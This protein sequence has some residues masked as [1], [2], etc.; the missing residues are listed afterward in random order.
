MAN[1]RADQQRIEQLR[2]RLRYAGLPGRQQYVRLYRMTENKPAIAWEASDVWC[3]GE[4]SIPIRDLQDGDIWQ[5]ILWLTRNVELLYQT[6]VGTPPEG[7]P[8]ALAAKCWLRDQPVVRA[9]VKEAIRR[10][11]SFPPDVFRYVYD[12]MVRAQDAPY[13]PWRDASAAEQAAALA[14]FLEAP[15]YISEKPKPSRTVML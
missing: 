13:Y 6:V 2:L 10:G 9:L 1:R 14:P 4:T 3:V 12:Y 8:L 11:L 7:S 5:V 15:I